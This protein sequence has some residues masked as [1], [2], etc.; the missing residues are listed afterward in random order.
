MPPQTR[1]TGVPGSS[2]GSGP[3]GQPSDPLPRRTKRIP[4]TLPVLDAKDKA[5]H[6]GFKVMAEAALGQLG[7]LK[8][9]EAGAPT[10]RL[11]KSK[12]PALNASNPTERQELDDLLATA[13]EEYMY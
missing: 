5:T 6:V 10:L 4:K 11:I 8:P 1:A 2:H 9:L 13:L 7:L 12:N 3:Q